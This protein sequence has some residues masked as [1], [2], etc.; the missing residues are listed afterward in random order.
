MGVK[1][2]KETNSPQSPMLQP[3]TAP[4][5]APAQVYASSA[6]AERIGTLPDELRRSFTWDQG[7][8]MARHRSFTVATDL[9]V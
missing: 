9:Q 8:E 7:K 4:P 2:L 1:E 5:C 3:S 6:L